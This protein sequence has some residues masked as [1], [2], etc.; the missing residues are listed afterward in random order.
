MTKDIIL[1]EA[2]ER[3]K[4][5]IGGIVESRCVGICSNLTK[6]S[7]SGKARIN[8][9]A[10]VEVMSV[11]WEQHSGETCFPIPGDYFCDLWEGSQLEL[12]ESL[13]EHLINKL[14]ETNLTYEEII[15]I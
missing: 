8:G 15:I 13:I 10:I 11:G 4:S 14:E 2:I 7:P 1:L 3:L 5:M 6:H 9:Y 12:R